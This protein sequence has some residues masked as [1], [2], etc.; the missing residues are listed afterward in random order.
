ME[1]GE[2]AYN[3]LVG[4]PGGKASLRIPRNKWEDNIVA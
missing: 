3:I 4:K 1:E 2:I